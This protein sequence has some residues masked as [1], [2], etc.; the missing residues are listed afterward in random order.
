MNILTLLISPFK[1]LWVVVS[2]PINLIWN[3]CGFL[4]HLTWNILILPFA[5]V[6]NIAKG[7]FGT[8]MAF[9]L[10]FIPHS[11]IEPSS[12]LSTS[13]PSLQTTTIS[14]YSTPTT[15]LAYNSPSV[16]S[17]TTKHQ[18]QSVRNKLSLAAYD[19]I[20]SGMSYQE[21]MNIL[22]Q[23]GKEISRVEIPGTS[24]TVMY[25]WEAQGGLKNMNAMFQDDA[26]ISKAQFG[27][28]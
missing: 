15:Q 21:V 6:G 16:I 28:N 26:L 4:I 24:T 7:I 18:N 12:S 2:F 5:L 19:Q 3:G 10:F 25:Q 22:G 14:S 11:P 1:L 27:L 9:I 8:F 23:K 17:S 20:Q 13:V